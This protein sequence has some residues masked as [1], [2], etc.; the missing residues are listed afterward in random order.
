MRSIE[1]QTTRQ[2]RQAYTTVGV[3]LGESSQMFHT[4][5]IHAC[6]EASAVHA[7]GTGQLQASPP[8]MGSMLSLGRPLEGR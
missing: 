3:K 8:V 2:R 1:D 7:S 6:N 5:M 4:L